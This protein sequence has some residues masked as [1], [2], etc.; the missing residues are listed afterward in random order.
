MQRSDWISIIAACVSFG[1]IAFNF[2]Q[3]FKARRAGLKFRMNIARS[4]TT[5]EAVSASG[6]RSM[7]VNAEQNPT[8]RLL[9]RNM[10]SRPSGI[11]EI[12][13]K[14]PHGDV[15]L[16]AG[17]QPPG[18]VMPLR[19]EPWAVEIITTTWPAGEHTEGMYF[20]VKDIDDK[21]YTVPD[22]TRNRRVSFGED[23]LSHFPRSL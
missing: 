1:A 18:G 11:V 2:F 23:V 13:A 5:T 17:G 19:I 9:I 12:R 20:V 15:L 16:D 14:N 10:S 8:T 3:Y 7:I 21:I 6:V 4:Y 22:Y